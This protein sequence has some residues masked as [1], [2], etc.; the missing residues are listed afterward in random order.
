MQD[1]LFLL[2][3][4]FFFECKIKTTSDDEIDDG[5]YDDSFHESDFDE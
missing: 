2:L 4:T 5:T 3:F 1:T